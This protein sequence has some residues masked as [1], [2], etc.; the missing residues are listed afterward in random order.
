VAEA[1]TN[2]VKHSQ[3]GSADVV[4]SVRDGMLFLRIRDDGIGGADPNGTGL[5]GMD[6]RVTA[7]GGRLKIES[8]AG[9]G[10]LVAATVPLLPD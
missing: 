5:V 8:R 4:A 3:A 6:D 10:T 1:L 9:E 7:L 2:V